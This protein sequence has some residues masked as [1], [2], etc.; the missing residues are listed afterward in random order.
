MP[1][2]TRVLNE[3]DL[4]VMGTGPKLKAAL[5]GIGATVALDSTGRVVG[6]MYGGRSHTVSVN[7]VI[8][9]G[10]SASLLA[11]L[12]GAIR[13][14]YSAE[15]IKAQAKRNGWAVKKISANKYQVIKRGA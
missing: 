9:A 12:K 11:E 15:I 13:V 5:E 2:Y 6:F 10:A 7:G 4:G 8:S 1:C 14:S 3:V